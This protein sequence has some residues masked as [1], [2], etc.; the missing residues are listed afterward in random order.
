MDESR[1]S[2]FQYTAVF[3]WN[4]VKI[5][6]YSFNKHFFIAFIVRTTFFWTGVID[7][8]KNVVDDIYNSEFFV[9]AKPALT[10]QDKAK[11]YCLAY[12]NAKFL[13]M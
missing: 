6:E 10:N 7:L 1:F 4:V 2:D 13:P 3:Q 8:A 11:D 5:S 12:N 9:V